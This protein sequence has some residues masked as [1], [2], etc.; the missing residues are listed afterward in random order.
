MKPSLITSVAVF[1][2]L[3]LCVL[4]QG[5]LLNVT[6]IDVPGADVTY[7]YDIDGDNVVG[8]YQDAAG[9]HGFV[10][11][12]ADFTSIDVPEAAWTYAYGIDGSNIVGKYSTGFETLGFIYDGTAYS[13]I[14]FPGAEDTIAYGVDGGVVVGEYQD[15]GGA[16]GFIYDGVTYVSLDMAGATRLSAWGIDGNH[17]VGSYN[18][19]SFHG[20]LYDRVASSYTTLDVPGA[21]S[22]HARGIADDHIVGGYCCGN[23][24]FIY[25]GSNYMILDVLGRTYVYGVD[26]EKVVGYY[27]DGEDRA[28]IATIPEP[29]TL[30]LLAVGMLVA[31]R[32]R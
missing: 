20:F 14:S 2:A 30:L 26:G 27:V 32:R 31:G 23:N 17:V 13:T 22:T 10:Y 9:R 19:G 28:F 11:D 1:L 12:G 25:N 6:T 4:V 5:E 16:H 21:T 15:A 18:D 7:A 8:S 29:T 3:F 24:G